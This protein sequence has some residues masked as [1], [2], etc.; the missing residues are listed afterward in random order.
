MHK[1]TSRTGRHG[2]R[3]RDIHTVDKAPKASKKIL[4]RENITTSITTTP[5]TA[6]STTT[7]QTGQHGFR[8]RD[9]HTVDKAPKLAR[10]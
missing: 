8:S 10:E 1:A 7:S 6:T 4:L 9:V 3:S 5:T 2:F